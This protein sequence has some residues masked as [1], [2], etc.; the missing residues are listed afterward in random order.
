MKTS[1]S[2]G[3][4]AV[5]PA[6]GMRAVEAE[7]FA[8]GRVTSRAAMERAG[9]GVAA[10][11]LRHRPPGRALVLCGPGNNGGDGFVVARLLAA[12]GWQIEAR[13]LGAGAA[14]G[15]DA[16]AM[17]HLWEGGTGTADLLSAPLPGPGPDLLVDALFG[18]GLARRIEGA[19]A[20][21]LAEISALARGAFRVAVDL[22]SGLDADRGTVLGMTLPADLSVTFHCRKPAHDLRPDL[23]GAVEIVDIGL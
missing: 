21:R 19:P 17:R 8:A 6:A 3:P 5:L 10:A 23:C 15:P 12:Q 16:A 4:V 20:V 9:Q 18:I 22:P 13:M 14:A 1:S 2:D 11:I 7:A